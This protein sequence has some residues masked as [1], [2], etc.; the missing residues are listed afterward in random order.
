MKDLLLLIAVLMIHC[1]KTK[2]GGLQH[3]GASLFF[4]G[5]LLVYVNES[6]RFRL[7]YNNFISNI[8]TSLL[9]WGPLSS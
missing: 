8:D 2:F 5:R 3:F 6:F 1:G 9:L 7:F 4:L